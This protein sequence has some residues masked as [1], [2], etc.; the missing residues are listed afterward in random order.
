MMMECSDPAKVVF[1]RIKEMEPANATKIVGYLLL[2]DRVDQEMMKLAMGPDSAILQV[3]HKA[4][5][6]LPQLSSSL[7]TNSSHS[8][9]HSHSPPIPIPHVS[10]DSP[11]SPFSPR[12]YPSPPTRLPRFWDSSE[13]GSGFLTDR[14]NNERFSSRMLP[15]PPPP[16]R[17]SNPNMNLNSGAVKTCN[18]YYNKGYCKHGSTCR[19]SHGRTYTHHHHHHQLSFDSDDHIYSLERLE[20]EIVELLKSRKGSPVSIASLPMMYYER[21]GK[22]LQADGYLTESQRHGKPGYSLTKLLARLSN[23]IRLIDR[24]HGQHA[25]ILAE[26]APNYPPA[27]RND[28]GPIVTGSRQIYLTFPADSTF[29]E[30]D[31]SNYFSAFGG[32]ADVRIPCQHKRMFG[33]V[34]FESSDTV[35]MVLAKGNPHY[36]CGARVLVKPYREKS[37]FG[38]RKYNERTDHWGYYNNNHPHYSDSDAELYSMQL[39]YETSRMLR[40][41]Q[42]IEEQEHN[43][44]NNDQSY[45]ELERRRLEQLQF[46]RK[47]MHNQ[48]YLSSCYSTIGLKRTPQDHQNMP[49]A[50]HSF[51][52]YLMDVLNSGSGHDDIKQKDQ[53][54]RSLGDDLPE[55][56]F[57]SPIS[58]S[59]ST[60]K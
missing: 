6:H 23:T 59:I 22:V 29:V 48:S 19:F 20:V 34:T 15:P 3:I 32:V 12:T 46:A 49:S 10:I 55:N 36:V 2:Q 54:N 44:N 31:V 33:F 38:D 26:D 8:H 42:L 25:V 30:D 35:R 53:D 28:P 52:Y 4:K 5:S 21:Y 58:S 37:K 16:R 47:A 45:V 11:F 39:G 17:Y 14:F 9:S 43:N 50:E 24:P 51:S 13:P 57:A 18:Y 27:D 1:N 41:Q 40:K 60:T 56:P 7:T